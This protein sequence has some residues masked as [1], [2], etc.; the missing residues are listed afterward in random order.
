MSATKNARF[1]RTWLPGAA[2]LGAALVLSSCTTVDKA[3]DASGGGTSAGSVVSSSASDAAIKKAW[4]GKTLKVG[5]SPPI[6]SEFYTQ[7]E[8]S[9]FN[10]MKEY[11]NRYGIKWTWE[12]QGAL[13]DADKLAKLKSEIGTTGGANA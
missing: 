4:G 10:R 7:I 12:R 1:R 2:V 13:N 11:E 6:L 8:K 3:D 5:F 9:A